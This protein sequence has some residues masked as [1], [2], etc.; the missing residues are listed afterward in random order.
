MGAT[1]EAN[2]EPL[3][4]ECPRCGCF[5]LRVTHSWPARNG[6]RRRRRQCRHCLKIFTTYEVT[7]AILGKLEKRPPA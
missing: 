2:G 7:A 3:G 5:D 6:R 4:L 1:T